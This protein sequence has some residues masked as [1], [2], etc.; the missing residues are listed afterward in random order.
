MGTVT[1]IEIPIRLPGLNEY[2]RQNRHHKQAGAR[3]KKQV[4]EQLLWYIKSQ[5]KAK[6]NRVRLVFRW[7]EA[8]RRRDLDNIAAAKKFLL[9]AMVKAGVIPGDG[10]RHV[11][12][13]EDH[14]EVS[15]QPGVRVEIMEVS[16][17]V[18]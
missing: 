14:F 16:D 6:H 17:G 11:V 10:W 18:A 3:M 2:T 7:R 15:K 13:F 9:D 8:D 4:E 12:G 5:T 1:V